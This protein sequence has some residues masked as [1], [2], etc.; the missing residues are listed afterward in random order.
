[1]A[2]A[3]K[4]AE[5]EAQNAAYREAKIL[6]TDSITSVTAAWVL[7]HVELTLNLDLDRRVLVGAALLTVAP[8]S[9]AAPDSMAEL[10]LDISNLDVNAVSLPSEGIDELP[11]TVTPAGGDS[12][13]GAVRIELPSPSPGW[14]WSTLVVKLEY[15]GVNGLYDKVEEFVKIRPASPSR[16]TA[17]QPH[18][19]SAAV[20]STPALAAG[21]SRPASPS[22]TAEQQPHADS[23][24]V[25]STQLSLSAALESARLAKHEG[26][27]RELGCELVADLADLVD[28]DLVELGLK[29]VE[30]T[31]L[32]RLSQAV[33]GPREQ[34]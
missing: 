20:L 23:A 10:V 26:A 4:I 29:R 17:Q 27:L 3:A 11:F 19:D 18:A 14:G 12:E 28:Q 25:L 22:R 24:K 7:T 33:G 32:R 6:Q 2:A 15:S 21:V 31:R 8:T 9:G 16:T 13:S 30:V 34:A 5:A 1:M